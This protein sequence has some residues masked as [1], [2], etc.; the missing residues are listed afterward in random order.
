M[1]YAIPNGDDAT[2]IT[3]NRKLFNYNIQ[4]H[5]GK[6]SRKSSGILSEY[7]KPTRSCV[8]FSGNF[9]QNVKNLCKNMKI[10][11]TFYEIKKL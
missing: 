5:R 7:E 8:I 2:R 3:F 6:Y 10:K 1:I 9:L 11:A 4:S